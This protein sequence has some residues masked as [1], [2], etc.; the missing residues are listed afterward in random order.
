MTEPKRRQRPRATG[1]TLS[2]MTLRMPQ[3]LHEAAEQ[4]AEAR[5]ITKTA[6][7]VALIAAGLGID[8]YDMNEDTSPTQ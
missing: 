6:H 5:G 1:E 3:K 2:A 7:I 4:Q 8:G